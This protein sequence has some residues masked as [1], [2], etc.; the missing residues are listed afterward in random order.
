MI[1]AIV[2]E[3]RRFLPAWGVMLVLPIP[4]LDCWNIADARYSALGYLF[5][6]SAILAGECFRPDPNAGIDKG[7]KAGSDAWKAKMLALILATALEVAFFVVVC[8]ALNEAP[9]SATVICL[10]SLHAV[11]P[12]LCIVPYFTVVTGKPY[13]AVIIAGAILGACKV[14]G[15][16]VALLVYG[17]QAE[18]QG[19]LSATWAHP[20]LLSLVFIIG[21]AVCSLLFYALGRRSFSRRYAAA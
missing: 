9:G 5:L 11:V 16:V 10:L 6:G 2:Q 13:A 19:Y 12:A 1:N 3:F 7:P 4:M 8:E 20:N 18:R 14:A 15:D 21:T 17:P